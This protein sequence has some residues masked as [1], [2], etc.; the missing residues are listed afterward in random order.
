[1]ATSPDNLPLIVDYGLPADSPTM[2][3]AAMDAVQAA[4][5]QH[6]DTAP[7]LAAVTLSSGWK[8]ATN[9]AGA[10]Q[11]QM[12]GKLVIARGSWIRTAA[13]T[14]TDNGFY[15][16]GT[17]P[18]GYRPATTIHVPIT[19]LGLS[20]GA[21]NWSTTNARILQDGAID[22]MANFAGSMRVDDFVLIGGVAWFTP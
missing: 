7:T 11:V 14:V 2:N 21:P 9:T 16:L 22:F 3:N 15:P 8:P 5:N 10:P 13:L 4:L 20:G 18:A 17:I 12:T 6:M 19:W 1:M